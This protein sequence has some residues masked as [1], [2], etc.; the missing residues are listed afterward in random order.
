MKKELF[1]Y[2]IKEFHERELP[3]LENRDLIIPK[4]NKIITLTGSRRAGK[5]FYF[6]QLIHAL[7]KNIPKERIIYINFEDDR[8]LPID[9]K[10]LNDILEAYYELY[11]E[12]KGKE[13]YLF[14]DE[15]QTIKGWESYIRRIND[16]EKTKIFITGSSS[17]LL[18]K[19]IA[20]SLRGRT[21]T[22]ELFP[23]SFKEFLRI[24]QIKLTKNIT[25][26]KERFNIKK[27]LQEYLTFGGFPEVVLEKN[28]LEYNILDEY[29][30]IMLF[31]DIIERFTVRN[32]HLLKKLSKFL[33]TNIANSFSVN[34]YYKSI[35][36]TA[37]V[38]KETLF[39][40]LSYL[41][42]A[43]MIFPIPIFSYSLKVQQTNP[44]KI[45]CIDNGLRNA[46]S[47]KFSKD[48][49][50][51]AE[52]LVFIELKRRGLE[53]YYW[54]NKG[55]VDFIVKNKNELIPI[56]VSYTNEINLRETKALLEFKE[57]A[58]KKVKEPIIITK[59]LEKKEQGIK[60]IPLWKWLLE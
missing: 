44:K 6:F 27:L 26:S 19:E 38:G 47:F 57:K 4:T 41:E 1:K 21:L 3:K 25:Y 18:S 40:Y 15:P 43:N 58:E 54:K 17:K 36:E 11:P 59:D 8:I 53:I 24:K 39:E 20:T 30:K 48:E 55:E 29:F 60:Y 12:N 7:L 42:E 31:R 33:L 14:F 50:K 23:L 34:S 2:I 56:N 45:Y 16:T 49:G 52:N 13:I 51:L 22:F 37:S 35:K 46:V 9:V 10:E 32:I 5:T 28:D